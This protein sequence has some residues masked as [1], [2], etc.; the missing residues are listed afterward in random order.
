MV[1][2]GRQHE[3]WSKST[4]RARDKKLVTLE[5][6]IRKMT[7]LA[8]HALRL[9][10]RGLIKEGFQADITVFDLKNV[11][12]LCTYENDARPAYPKGIPYVFINGVPVIENYKLTGA[13]PGK[14]LKHSSN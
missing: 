9:R 14:V 12:S 3:G 7:S 4:P 6:M 5:D 1:I 11:K 10:D 2:I 13:L 8:A